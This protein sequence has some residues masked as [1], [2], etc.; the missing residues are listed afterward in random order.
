MKLNALFLNFSLIFSILFCTDALK[1]ENDTRNLTTVTT[2]VAKKAERFQDITLPGTL[3]AIKDTAIRAR[4][5]GY[6]GSYTADLGDQVKEGQT[7]ATIESPEVDQDF[8]IALA[9]Y[10]QAKANLALAKV[11]AI[12]WK[13]LVEQKAVSQ[14]EVDQKEADYLV[15]KADLNVAQANVN[16]YEELKNYKKIIAPFNGRIS[17]R[18]IDVGSLINAGSGP[19]LFHITQSDMLRVYVNIPQSAIRNLTI[20]QIADV[21]V[22]EYPHKVFAAHISRISSALDSTSRTLLVEVVLPNREGIILPGMFCQVHLKIPQVEVAIIIPS[23]DIIIR[24]DGTWV[25]TLPK[26]G[27][28]HLQKVTLGRDFGSEIEI[29][30]GL[31]EGTRC[32]NN[33]S[34]TLQED[35]VVEVVDSQIH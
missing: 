20:G 35:Q 30:N 4:T 21:L 33:P 1:A 16:K 10:E 18:N 31:N 27:K 3:T 19:E 28:I 29:L 12:R 17:A 32:V 26:E 13:N 15:R 2:T 22:S 25:A 34:D 9:N 11:T 7:L 23:N 14:Q 5:N 8:N 6:I 24:A